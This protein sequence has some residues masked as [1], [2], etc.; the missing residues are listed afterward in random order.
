MTA[1]K[2][3]PVR[4]TLVIVSAV[5]TT[6]LSMAARADSE[7]RDPTPAEKQVVLKL[8]TVAKKTIVAPL[9]ATGWAVDSQNTAFE[10]IQVASH[11]GPV[12]PLMVCSSLFEEKLTADPQSARGQEMA[13]NIATYSTDT[14]AK[15]VRKLARAMQAANIEIRVEPNNPYMRARLTD[16]AP[17][18]IPG[19]PVAYRVPA[20]IDPES[21]DFVHVTLCFGD[22]HDFGTDRYVPYPFAHPGG[23]AFIENACV[24][25]NGIPETL[26]SLIKQIGW[27]ALEQGLTR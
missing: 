12:R 18:S 22:W 8:A 14:S 27:A 4:Q 10:S 7:C 19:V 6:A 17:L 26:D 2:T 16:F 13:R 5:V 9:L 20:H 15:G 21:P 3:N 1:R 23:T 24:E 11:P 25:L